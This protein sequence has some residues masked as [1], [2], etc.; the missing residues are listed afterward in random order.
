MCSA[1]LTMPPFQITKSGE[2]SQKLKPRSLDILYKHGAG[3]V[4]SSPR[5]HS[6]LTENQQLQAADSSQYILF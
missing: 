4:H 6:L 5:R 1:V 3:F 2:P